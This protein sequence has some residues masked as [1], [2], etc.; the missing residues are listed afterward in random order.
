[1]RVYFSALLLLLLCLNSY[2]QKLSQVSFSGAATLSY[3]SFLTDQNVLIRVSPDGKL[4]EWGTEVQSE[5]SSQ[6]YAPKLQQF[7]G[8]VDYYPDDA[9]SAYR[10]KVKSIGTCMITYYNS[11]DKDEKPGKL[12]SI[13]VAALDYYTRFE[14]AAYK[15]KLRFA[16]SLVLEYYP[17]LEN[18]AFR[19]KLKSIGGTQIKYHS[20]FDDKLLQGKVK[21]IGSV[22]YDWGSSLD[23]REFRGSLKSGIYRQM[24]NGITYIL[25]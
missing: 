5:R 15:G 14:N 3:F 2:S 13:G 4:M 11:L 23:R 22:N 8:R 16:G 19:G 6:Y 12:K 17:A 1:M 20:S 25:R 18:E 21:S 7:M 9:D 24:I 10:G